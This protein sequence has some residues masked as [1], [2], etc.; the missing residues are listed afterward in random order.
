MILILKYDEMVG[1][2][3]IIGILS[4]PATKL[5]EHISKRRRKEQIEEEFVMLLENELQS[6]LNAVNSLYEVFFDDFVP[7]INELTQSYSHTLINEIVETES[8]YL[9]S[10]KNMLKSHID[11]ARSCDDIYEISS[12]IEQLRLNNVKLFQFIETMKL[13]Y[14]PNDTV[15][16][17]GTFLK[18][19]RRL[20][21]E[22]YD[23]ISKEDINRA[24]KEMES[25]VEKMRHV[26][27]PTKSKGIINRSARRELENSAKELGKVLKR[28]RIDKRY[29]ENM[30]NYVPKKMLPL[31]STTEELIKQQEEDQDYYKE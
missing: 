31:I 2:E 14:N 28:I 24:I 20:G 12:F 23:E 25:I 15:N 30:R 10:Y 5:V 17:D 21:R 7:K 11:I 16:I 9:T 13:S 26:V 3:N 19:F 1:A 29:T 27:N 4:E 22:V 8:K 18:S 6:Y